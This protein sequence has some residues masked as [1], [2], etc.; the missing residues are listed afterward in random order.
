MRRSNHNQLLK[1]AR[2]TSGLLP[3]CVSTL[4]DF[5]LKE[6][7]M[8]CVYLVE[9]TINRKCYI[10]KTIKTLKQRKCVHTSISKHDNS[11]QLF[12]N[13][14]RKYGFKNFEWIKIYKSKNDEKLIEKEIHF[15]KKY[16][17]KTPHGYNL[18][19]GGEGIS[20]FIY[21]KETRK[22]M[23]KA[24]QGHSVSKETR[25][26]MSKAH[27]GKIISKSTRKKMSESHKNQTSG[28]L[29][30]YHTKETRKKMS[31][32]H[33][34]I[35]EE[36]RKK[37]SKS[38]LGQISPMRGK[39]HSKQSIRKMSKA[40]KGITKEINPNLAH[41][42]ETK[43]RISKTHKGMPK[44]K[45]HKRKLSISLKRLWQNPE[46]RENQLKA[47]FPNKQ[48]KAKELRGIENET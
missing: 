38:H 42:E 28:M 27:K 4:A 13:A 40:K 46:Y 21:S 43:R 25:K 18:T 48:K 29:G 5:Y 12:H 39:H 24:L 31:K 36:T 17:T 7:T 22:K 20:G 8:G 45:R 9:N 11:K 30:K 10:G 15:I 26:K 2:G 44:P 3:I 1:S 33:K 35:S 6:I 14:L 32:N 41:S 16:K 47:I 37:M 23:S 19:D 34:N